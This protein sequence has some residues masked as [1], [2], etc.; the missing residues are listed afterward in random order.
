M[1]NDIKNM[2]FKVGG[3]MIFNVPDYITVYRDTEF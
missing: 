2:I 1:G 3:N